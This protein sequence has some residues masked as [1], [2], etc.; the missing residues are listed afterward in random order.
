M[1]KNR[2]PEY[3]DEAL[4]ACLEDE[5]IKDLALL[6][7][8]EDDG[9]RIF[10]DK[11]TCVVPVFNVTFCDDTKRS[12]FLIKGVVFPDFSDNSFKPSPTLPISPFSKE[13]RR[14]INEDILRAHDKGRNYVYKVMVE[15]ENGQMYHVYAAWTENGPWVYGYLNFN[16]ENDSVIRTNDLSGISLSPEMLEMITTSKGC[17]REFFFPT[18]I[19]E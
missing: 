14:K 7:D 5:S 16:D 19:A 3:T 2:S 15:N 8:V 4:F 18:K 6:F 1:L 13:E 11:L 9:S 12:G 17:L 10:P